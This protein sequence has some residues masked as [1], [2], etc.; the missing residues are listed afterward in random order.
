[1]TTWLTIVRRRTRQKGTT[2]IINPADVGGK[3]RER[4]SENASSLTA[5]RAI[6]LSSKN[7]IE[8]QN[9]GPKE[10]CSRSKAGY[11]VTGET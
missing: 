2:S 10:Q 8:H 4:L 6:S 11:C 5:V 7:I 3:L 9:L 1:M